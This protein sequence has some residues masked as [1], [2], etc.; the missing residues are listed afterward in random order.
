MKLATWPKQRTYSQSPA[1]QWA[2][3][4]PSDRQ[5]DAKHEAAMKERIEVQS[6]KLPNGATYQR[7]RRVGE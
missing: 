2:W 1:V 5:L 4:I 7:I 3:G 6:V